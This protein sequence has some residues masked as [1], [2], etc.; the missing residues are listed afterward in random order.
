MSHKDK[1]KSA[2]DK[3]F[4]GELIGERYRVGRCLGRGAFGATYRGIDVLTHLPVAIKVEHAPKKKRQKPPLYV[5]YLMYNEVH[6]GKGIPAIEWYGKCKDRDVLVMELLGPSLERIRQ[7]QKGG[8]LPPQIVMDLAVQLLRRLEHCHAHG[9]IH[10]DIKPD[11]IVLGRDRHRRR[12]FV[13]DFGL[14]K[15]VLTANG[16]HIPYRRGKKLTGSARYCS[17][18]TH[19]GEEQSR[20]DDL[21]SLAYTLIFFLTGSLPW[22]GVKKGTK[23]ERYQS[24]GKIKRDTTVEQ[25]CAPVPEKVRAPVMG[26]LQCARTMRFDQPPPYHELRSAFKR[27]SRQMRGRSAGSRK[28]SLKQQ[29]TT[30]SSHDYNL[31]S[32]FHDDEYYNH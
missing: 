15:H 7:A 24:I 3:T 32:S 11:N 25:I 14:A 1:V 10:R 17:L 13:V 4:C 19:L 29:T 18:A 28:D 6:P 16:E 27:V 2:E 22:Q 12:C 21:E 9:V 30:L 5:E 8:T 23:S 26:L 20:R 31:G